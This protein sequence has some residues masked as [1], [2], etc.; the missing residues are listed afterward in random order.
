MISK[1]LALA[2]GF[3][4]LLIYDSVI[5]DI[6]K[7]HERSNYDRGVTFSAVEYYNEVNDKRDIPFSSVETQEFLAEA[8]ESKNGR[9]IYRYA[10]VLLSESNGDQVMINKAMV[11]LEE[12]VKVGWPY[13]MSGLA[14]I[15]LG[16]DPYTGGSKANDKL[17]YIWGNIAKKCQAANPK[18]DR[19]LSSIVMKKKDSDDAMSQSQNIALRYCPYGTDPETA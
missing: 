3:G 19:A 6:G 1:K 16:I 7:T 17:G 12:S 4:S 14:A 13:S 15:Y 9:A 8:I 18:L 11:G 10:I 2:I 5:R